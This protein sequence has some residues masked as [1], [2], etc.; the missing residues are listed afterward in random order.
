MLSL[1]QF[2]IFFNLFV[3]ITL[4][5]IFFISFLLPYA[6]D[7]FWIR[8]SNCPNFFSILL[9]KKLSFEINIHNISLLYYFANFNQLLC[10]FMD[11]TETFYRS[12]CNHSLFALRVYFDTRSTIDRIRDYGE[13][14]FAMRSMEEKRLE[15]PSRNNRII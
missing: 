6:I 7:D 13:N 5:N 14:H 2:N 10:Y 9:F 4:L 8:A 15:Q 12:L 11:A 1:N 3:I